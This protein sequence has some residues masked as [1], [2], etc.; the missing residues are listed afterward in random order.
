MCAQFKANSLCIDTQRHSAKMFFWINVHYLRLIHSASTDGKTRS[1]PCWRM[2][3][4]FT[5][6]TCWTSIRWV[7]K[8]LRRL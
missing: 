1:H 5:D 8:C 6:W 7:L 3:L 4:I 2:L